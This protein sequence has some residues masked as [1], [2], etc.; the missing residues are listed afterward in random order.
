[1]DAYNV[2]KNTTSGEII[3]IVLFLH[4]Y[5]EPMVL[6]KVAKMLGNKFEELLFMELRFL[7]SMQDVH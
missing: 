2:Y 6:A 1:M 4:N 5:S 3:E 7:G